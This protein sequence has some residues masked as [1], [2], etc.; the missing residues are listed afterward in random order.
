MS[1]LYNELGNCD[2][3]CFVLDISELE[4][5][6]I[7]TLFYYFGEQLYVKIMKYLK[8]SYIRFYKFLTEN[9]ILKNPYLEWLRIACLI[10]AETGEL[11]M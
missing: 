6:I 3:R 8:I 11:S 9:P 1:F 2:Y 7:S 5:K 4:A 10:A